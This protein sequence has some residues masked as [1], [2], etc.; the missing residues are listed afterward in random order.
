MDKL[1]LKLQRF[2]TRLYGEW[3]KRGN[4]KNN[5]FSTK[6]CRSYIVFA[7]ELWEWKDVM[8]KL[9]RNSKTGDHPSNK[10]DAGYNFIIAIFSYTL[11]GTGT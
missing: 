4:F 10:G 1:V 7:L 5:C 6:W 2:F 11:P 9:E 8:P 3:K